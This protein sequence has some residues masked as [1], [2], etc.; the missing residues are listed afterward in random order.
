M[1]SALSKV[2]P[3]QI[4]MRSGMFYGELA[5]INSDY[6]QY[7]SCLFFYLSQGVQSRMVSVVNFFLFSNIFFCF[8]VAIF[9]LVHDVEPIFHLP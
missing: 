3:P 2:L 4:L 7:E 8:V 5:R 1:A 6:H 9:D